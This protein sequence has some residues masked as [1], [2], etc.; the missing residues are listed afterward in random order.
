M[1]KCLIAAINKDDRE[2]CLHELNQSLK[3]YLN[4][5][6][7]TQLVL[8]ENPLDVI[9]AKANNDLMI[10]RKKSF[11]QYGTTE[12]E[13]GKKLKKAENVKVQKTV[14]KGCFIRLNSVN[15]ER[16]QIKNVFLDLDKD[17]NGYLEKREFEMALKEMGLKFNE[18][19]RSDIFNK[20]DSDG[21]GKIM[22]SEF[23]DFFLENI[24]CYE[25]SDFCQAFDEANK[26]G[27]GVVNFKE[28]SELVRTRHGS[29]SLD[30]VLSSFDAL[31]GGDKKDE[32]SCEDFIQSMSIFDELGL[33]PRKILKSS[34]SHDSILAISMI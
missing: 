3:H 10:K 22:F 26:K 33:F 12:K 2:P 4:D 1:F 9:D 15:T 25:K 18:S 14:R 16:E 13:E 28:F 31:C 21:N 7:P 23:Y 24:L 8:S 29:V 6:S 20:I 30:K 34:S 5:T 17:G 32:L 19:E 11:M 27:R